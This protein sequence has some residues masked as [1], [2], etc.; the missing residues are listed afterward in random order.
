[1]AYC[2][3]FYVLLLSY[4]VKKL[5]VK[6]I[7]SVA[8]LVAR[9]FRPDKSATV[10]ST[11]LIERTKIIVPLLLLQVLFCFVLFLFLW[12]NVLGSFFCVGFIGTR[13]SLNE[14]VILISFFFFH[15]C[16]LACTEY[17][18]R[19]R[20]GTCLDS[21]RRCD[22]RNDCPDASDEENCGEFSAVSSF[23]LPPPMP[24]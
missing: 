24:R 3:V 4:Y 17:Q 19:C 23:P 13:I 5:P 21:R 10:S 8:L 9:A 15:S 14:K 22:Q 7:S 18:F 1:M 11:V 20:D 12:F 16:F 2:V 6:R